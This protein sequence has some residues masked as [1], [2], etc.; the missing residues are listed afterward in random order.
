[1]RL[2]PPLLILFSMLL[3]AD[4]PAQREAPPPPERRA[5]PGALPPPPPRMGEG[6]SDPRA[7]IQ[8]V[9]EIRM[10]AMELHHREERLVAM[11]DM[12]LERLAD[13]TIDKERAERIGK[14]VKLRRELLP[15][16][17]EEFT[18]EVREKTGRTLERIRLARD[19]PER[20]EQERAG[21]FLDRLETRLVAIHDSATD[22]DTL[23]AEMEQFS[24]REGYPPAPGD[25]LR[26]REIEAL[27]ERLERLEQESA[28]NRSGRERRRPPRDAMDP[29]MQAEF[30]GANAPP[31]EVEMKERR[32]PER[33]N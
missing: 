27:R 22:F 18:A 11:E 25:E 7:L 29:E 24:P 20:L 33:K 21:F 12:A 1:M 17:K 19:T 30:P 28:L 13:G 14:I 6:L 32:G 15:L 9:H 2:L 8:R 5:A 3:V 16:E 31:P 26:A 10:E 4:T 23:F